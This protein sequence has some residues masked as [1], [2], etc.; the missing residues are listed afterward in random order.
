ME[1]FP[2]KSMEFHGIPWRFFTWGGG[3]QKETVS[4]GV[5][6]CLQCFFFTASLLSKLS[7]ILLGQCFKAS[8]IVCIDYLLCMIG[9]ML[10]S[11]GLHDSFL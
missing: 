7:V 11:Y 8:V 9:Q 2:W 1:N 10:F 5:G 3:V 6:G 4:K